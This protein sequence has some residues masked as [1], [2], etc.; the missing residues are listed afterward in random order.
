MVVAATPA[1]AG[2]L[3]ARPPR[4][5]CFSCWWD[6]A[7]G[8]AARAH[9]RPPAPWLRA[10]PPVHANRGRVCLVAQ[11]QCGGFC[12]FSQAS[13]SLPDSASP[14]RA[15][16]ILG[17][18]LRKDACPLLRTGFGAARLA[19]FSPARPAHLRRFRLRRRRRRMSQRAR[20]PFRGRPVHAG[21]RPQP[22]PAPVGGAIGGPSLVAVRLIAVRLIGAGLV[23]CLDRACRSAS[24]WS[25]SDRSAPARPR[26][27]GSARR[28][29]GHRFSYP[30]SW[31]ARL[32]V[33]QRG[34]DVVVRRIPGAVRAAGDDGFLQPQVTADPVGAGRR[35]GEDLDGPQRHV[36]PA[37]PLQQL[38]AAA[39]SVPGRSSAGTARCRRTRWLR[40]AGFRRRP[41][42]WCSAGRPPP[43]R[44]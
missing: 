28:R 3:A 38:R 40:A 11:P 30:V 7:P 39:G 17:S 2:A 6:P 31:P 34:S 4:A 12:S 24:G 20:L 10:N 43:P 27:H 25:A 29:N 35:V 37:Q 22:T 8:D 15:R 41:G 42:R 23:T 26:R 21:L 9:P 13:W 36:P 16:I 19:D 18:P 1:Q 44:R 33:G 14:Q 5:S 32:E